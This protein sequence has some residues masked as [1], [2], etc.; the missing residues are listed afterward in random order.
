[1][2]SYT[3]F[4]VLV[5]LLSCSWTRLSLGQEISKIDQDRLAIKAMAGCFEVEFKYTETFAPEVDYEK[6]YDYN[7]SALEWAELVEDE[8]GKIVLQHL[9]V[10]NDT[11][12]IKHWRQD[13]IYEGTAYWSYDHAYD[14]AHRWI[15]KRHDKQ[16]VKGKWA[17]HVYQVDDSPR[18]GG[19]ATWTHV[20]GKSRWFN[21]TDAPLPRREYSKRSDY[22]L[23]KRGN[24]V[25]I[26]EEG[27]LHEQDND[28]II[29]SGAGDRLLV[30]EKGYNT[31]V[32][33]PDE[34]CGAAITWWENNETKWEKIRGAWEEVY[35]E[36]EEVYMTDKLDDK[37]LYEHLF[38]N[39]IKWDK[40]SIKNQIE[41]YVN[42][43]S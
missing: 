6:A 21:K 39:D 37:R 40:K 1:M 14:N 24:E 36:T 10:I 29:R 17:Q 26:Q 5:L 33:V 41:A 9:L 19:I 7:A 11:M 31:Y 16:A 32:R 28:K 2:K 23:M 35:D 8:K 38:K 34:K 4:S 12:I 18:Y 27:W 22:N 25:V 13:W 20:D 3:I 43:R 30:Q 42:A 15:K